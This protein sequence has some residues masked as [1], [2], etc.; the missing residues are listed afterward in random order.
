LLHRICPLLRRFSAAGNDDLTTRSGDRRPK[1]AKARNRT[2]NRQEVVKKVAPMVS[3]QVHA[4]LPPVDCSA[5]SGAAT[6]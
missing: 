1:S 4:I 6:R 2:T 3:R 5:M